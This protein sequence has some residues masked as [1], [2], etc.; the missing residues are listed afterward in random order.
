MSNTVA[1][2]FNLYVR[3]LNVLLLI[4]ISFENGRPI[5]FVGDFLSLSLSDY[6]G[7]SFFCWT[8]G[9][10]SIQSCWLS[11]IYKL[12]LLAIHKRTHLKCTYLYMRVYVNISAAYTKQFQIVFFFFFQIRKKSL[13]IF[14]SFP[15]VSFPFFRV[16]W[17]GI[18]FFFFIIIIFSFEIYSK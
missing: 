7:V 11:T 1:H 6:L 5:R 3:S 4:M 16:L 14:M 17:A 13:L 9:F 8:T 12:P 15:L 18:Y 10:T 2:F